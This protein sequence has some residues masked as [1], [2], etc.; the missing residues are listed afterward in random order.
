MTS[1]RAVGSHR[2]AFRMRLAGDIWTTDGKIGSDVG[3]AS[4]AYQ[5]VLLL[6]L[7]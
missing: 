2:V 3:W 6:K 1:W 7:F 4:E 5:R